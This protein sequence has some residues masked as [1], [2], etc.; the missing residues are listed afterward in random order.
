[1]RSDSPLEALYAHFPAV[2]DEMPAG[3]TSHEFILQ[4]AQR[5]QVAYVAALGA[6][7]DGGEPFRAVHQQLSAHLHRIETLVDDGVAASH[8]IFGNSNSCKKWR[9][10]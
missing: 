7:L 9:K 3:F 8:D 5:H 4:L 2:I 1:M 10:A 6:Y